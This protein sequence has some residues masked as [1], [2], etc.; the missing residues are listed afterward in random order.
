VETVGWVSGS[1]LV[2]S[3]TAILFPLERI[4]KGKASLLDLKKEA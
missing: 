4:P 2:P 3:L 1:D